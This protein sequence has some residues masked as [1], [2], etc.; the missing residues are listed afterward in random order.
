MTKKGKKQSQ[1]DFYFER[2]NS[3]YNRLWEQI[4]EIG[5]LCVE[6][7]V[8]YF[9]GILAVD[10][11]YPSNFEKMIYVTLVIILID[12]FCMTGS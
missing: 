2:L 6:I 4:T 1:S 10:T 5:V 3:K 9:I 12:S 8:V 7:I 11:N